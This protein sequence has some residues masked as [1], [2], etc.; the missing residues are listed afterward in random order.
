MELRPIDANELIEFPYSEASGTEEQ[1][2]DWI[3]TCGLD[4]EETEEKAKELC[5]TV[6]NGFINVIKTAPTLTSPP[7][8]PLTLDELRG[9]EG[10][11]VWLETGEVIIKEQIIGCWEI[12]CGIT[13]YDNDTVFW[14]TRRVR[15][16]W[17]SDYGKTWLAYRHPPD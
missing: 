8:K 2:A 10:Q 11:P 16:F 13:R 9:M 5:W 12:V 14:L 4:K 3:A 6:I 7:N 15:G 17:G 1:I